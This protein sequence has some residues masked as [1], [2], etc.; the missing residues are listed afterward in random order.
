MKMFLFFLALFFSL[1][2]QATLLTFPDIVNYAPNLVMIGVVMMGLLRKPRYA[3]IFGAII[4]LVEDIN[5]ANFLGETAFAYALGGYLSGYFRSLVMRES[6]LLAMLVSGLCNELFDW[7]TFASSRLF[8][9]NAL[10]AHAMLLASSRSTL[11]TMLAMILL[12]APYRLAFAVKP[13]V[14]YDEHTTDI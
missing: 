1:I 3:L 6:L 7:F 11:V 14:A 2:L 5:Y 10:G 4:G 9:T 12:Y 13:A 8:G